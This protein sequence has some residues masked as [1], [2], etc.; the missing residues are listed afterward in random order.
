MKIHKLSPQ[1]GFSLLEL[2]IVLVM[3]GIL[4]TLALMQLGSSP[5]DLQRQRMARE[6]KIYLERA[7]FDSVKRRAEG[8]AE[9]A[10]VIL[11]G[12]ASFTALLD[13]DGDGTMRP[14]ET[15]T[16]DFADRTNATIRVS[17]TWSYPVTL[18]FDRRGLVTTVDGLGNSVTPL[19]TIC[20][21]CSDA[22][23]DITRISVSTSGTVAELRAGQNP[24]A[25]PTPTSTNQVAPTTNCYVLVNANA[26]SACIPY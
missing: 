25:L 15:R 10:K 19:F 4:T 9:T 7:R 26:N 12:P 11:N 16:V 13:L 5:V 20:S 6:F 17:D 3:I 18:A 1:S 24:Q 2:L 8:T 21:D 23:P 14:D 22:S